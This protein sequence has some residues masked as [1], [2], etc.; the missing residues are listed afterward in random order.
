MS[1][2]EPSAFEEKWQNYWGEHACFAANEDPNKPKYYVLCMFPY[3]SGS[4][5]HV[6]HPLSYTAVDIV[7]RYKMMNGFSVLNPMGWDAFGLP[8]ERAAMRDGRHPAVITQENIANFKNQLTKLG[9]AFCWEREVSTTDVDYYKWTQWIFLKLYEKGLAYLAEVPVN[10]CPAQGTVL[11]NEEVVDGKY[12][13][14]G[15]LVERRMMKQWMLKITAYAQR[16]LD[17]LEDLDWPA[18]VLEMQ[19]QWIGR[20]EGAE[21]QFQVADTAAHFT[22]YT[23]RPDTLFGATYCVLAPEHPLVA[24]ITS[25]AQK[26]AVEAYI[27]EASNR[28]DLDRQVQSEKTKTGVWTGAYAINPVN[29]EKIPIWVA[30]YVLMSY[31]TGAIMAVPAHDERDHAFAKVFELPIVAVYASPDGHDVQ[32]EAWTGDGLSINAG[33]FNGLSVAA[34]KAAVI[35]WIEGQGIGQRQVNFKLRDWLFSRQRYWGEPFPILHGE[36]GEIIPVDVSDLPISLPHIDAYRPTEDGMPPLARATDWLHVTQGGQKAVRECNTMPQWAG[37]CWYYLRY[38]DPKNTEAPFSEEAVNYWQNVDLYIGGVEHAVLHLLYARFWHKV[39]YDCGLVP[40][41]EPFQKLFNQGML[42]AYSY[43]DLRGKYHPLTS[44]EH[45]PNSAVALVPAKWPENASLPTELSGL[46][47]FHH[48]SVDSPTRSEHFLTADG[49]PLLQSVEK[50]GKSKQNSVDPLEI[51]ADYGADTLR[52]YEMFMGPLDQVKPWQT[53]GCDG[54]F[55]FLAKVWR[56]FLDEETG[57]PKAFG[58]HRKPVYKALQVAIKESTEGIEQ[59]KFN[60]PIAKMMEFVKACKGELPPREEALSFLLIL[61]PYAP[62]IAE[63]LYQKCLGST[64]SIAH[65]SWPSTDESALRESEVELPVMISGK[66][67]SKIMVA[68]DAD[69]DTVLEIAKSQQ[70]IQRYIEGK[71]ILRVIYRAGRMINLVVK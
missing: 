45:K 8:A 25:E 66:M 50:M 32:E 13:E 61:S 27:H 43:R 40:T 49:S 60:T 56:L 59:L 69:E 17:D 71:N 20:S 52:M 36:D 39:L 11:A 6:G 24:D 4:G 57:E 44:V 70:N 23:T 9:F 47:V 10:W 68:V 28:S 48:A 34:C 16:L 62:H 31:G 58:A 12:V 15:D 33:D 35:D 14:T 41:K 53:S 55:R 51:V 19:R 18:G 22:V 64:E 30:D 46:D 54:I 1:R 29:Q 3:P 37:S 63:E 67:R 65:C 42:L 2:Y 38:M 5:L 26:E 7:A 21:V